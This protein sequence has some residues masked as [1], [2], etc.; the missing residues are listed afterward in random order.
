MRRVAVIG[1]GLSGLVAARELRECS[2]VTVFEKSHGYGGDFE[3]NHGAQY[4]TARSRAFQLSL[5]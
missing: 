1:A 3:F 4:F 2:E 5:P